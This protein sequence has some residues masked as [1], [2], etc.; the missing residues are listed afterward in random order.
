MI[1]GHQTKDTDP[2]KEEDEA[3]E[4]SDINVGERL[5]VIERRFEKV[6][7]SHCPARWRGNWSH[8]IA[9]LIRHNGLQ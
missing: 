5:I 6:L 7:H 1:E 2:A 9:E 8:V 3:K 4:N